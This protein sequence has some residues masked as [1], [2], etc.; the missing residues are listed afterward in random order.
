MQSNYNPDVLSC[1]ANL[2]NDEVFTP[3]AVVNKMLDMLPAELWSR[4]SAT[5]LD[6]V[7]K[8]GVFLREIAKRLMAGLADEIPDVQERANH[9][10]TKQLYG[11]A[12]TELTS[13]L[14]R[15]SLYCSKRA[16]GVLSVCTAF[17]SEEGNILFAPISHTWNGGRC[18]FCGASQAIFERDETLES[19]AYQFIHT[20]TPEKIFNNMKFDVIIGNPPYQL[21]TGGGSG[22]GAIPIYNKFIQQAKK[23]N[24]R[25]LTMIVPSRWF[26]VG[27]GLDNFRDEMLND[28]RLR[29]IID[30]SNCKDCFPGLNIN[31]GINYFLWDS[32]Y[33][34]DCLFTNICN[35]KESTAYR[36]LNEFPIFIR[37]NEAV[38]VIQK[39]EL[40]KEN[41]LSNLI[42]SQTPFGILTNVYG[43][44]EQ[45]L[46]SITLHS[47]K[48]VGYIS[49]ELI[50]RNVNWIPK[51]KVLLGK[52]ISG[53]AGEMDSN[54]QAKIIATTKV[55]GK[56]EVCTQTYLVVGPYETAQMA[57]NCCSYLKTKFVRFLMFPQMLSISIS[58]SS[59]RFVPLQDF[60]QE[61]TD[62]KLYAKYGLT[63]EEIAFIESMIRPM[64]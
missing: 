57:D 13:L 28:N 20:N 34:G 25:Y 45:H 54:G 8:T 55:I 5:F 53:H 30:Y 32:S 40:M 19:H 48:G 58:K 38:S 39:V 49:K 42:S 60:T 4:S 15:R 44:K 7:S 12:I 16:N 29:Q 47:S 36:K 63:D 41:K 64:K 51:Y 43:D 35:N 18:E 6:P 17:N 2:S 23:L 37:H 3:P 1:L 31:G 61:W 9:I 33:N 14:S 50:T 26:S 46:N 27:T 22:S 11:I 24:P 62:E 56:N 21:N 59:F 52:A 10:F